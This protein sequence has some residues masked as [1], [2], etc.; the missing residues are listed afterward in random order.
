MSI[1]KRF[2]TSDWEKDDVADGGFGVNIAQEKP[3]DETWTGFGHSV[4]EQQHDMELDQDDVK[5]DGNGSEN[6]K[7]K[8]KEKI[9]KPLTPEALAAFEAA[10]RRAGIIYVSRIPPGMRPQKLRHIMSGYGEVGRIY[11]AFE[12][13]YVLS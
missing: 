5:T 7:G 2:N 3:Q 4:T 6:D 11:M 10:Q 12:G 13:K 9:L 1:D 8:G